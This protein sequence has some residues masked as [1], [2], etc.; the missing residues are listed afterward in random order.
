MNVDHLL[1]HPS[2]TGMEWP[3]TA[4]KPKPQEMQPQE[5]QAAQAQPMRAPNPAEFIQKIKGT[6]D[7]IGFLGVA[8][9]MI[10]ALK[11]GA[12][13]S[14]AELEEIVKGFSFQGK[15]TMENQ[16]FDTT[17]GRLSISLELPDLSKT[18][19]QTLSAALDEA[20]NK[21]ADFKKQLSQPVTQMQQAQKESLKTSQTQ[22]ADE[23]KFGKLN[24]LLNRMD[25]TFAAFE[26]KAND[27]GN[28]IF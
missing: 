22:M 20:Q 1:N 15:S 7:A 5:V 8:Q 28:K 27:L 19:R 17:S 13:K 6:N 9:N 12:E 24:A 18:D 23:G 3:K 10:D 11:S 21:I 26:N 14:T 25:D 16:T 2:L 4:A